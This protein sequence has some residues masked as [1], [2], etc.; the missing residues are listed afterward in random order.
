MSLWTRQV[1]LAGTT[2][3]LISTI[4]S[5]LVVAPATVFS[6][7]G[8]IP[9]RVAHSIVGYYNDVA[10]HPINIDVLINNNSSSIQSSNGGD[11]GILV[12]TV[13]VANK[14]GHLVPSDFKV[15]V[16]GNDPIPSS[17][18]GNKS[19]TFVKLHMGM[20]SV[21]ALGPAGYAPAFSGDCSGGMMSIEVK[22]CMI[23]SGI[24]DHITGK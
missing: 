17:F 10:V 14:T 23:T 5:S 9:F 16:H 21:T 19:G 18:N 4:F 24:P 15:S 12:V 7:S 2:I 20:Y 8:F 6:Y 3:S 1:I 13:N 11:M 22:K